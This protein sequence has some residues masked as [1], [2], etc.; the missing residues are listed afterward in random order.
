M[1]YKLIFKTMK[2]KFVVSILLITSTF[3]LTHVDAAVDTAAFE[4]AMKI[5]NTAVT[6]ASTSFNLCK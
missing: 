4:A 5:K 6:D 3:V 1:N 2:M